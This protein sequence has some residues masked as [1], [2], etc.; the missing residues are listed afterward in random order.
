MESDAREFDVAISEN[1]EGFREE[2][3]RMKSDDVIG[4]VSI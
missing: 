2:I 3:K 1:G 4:R